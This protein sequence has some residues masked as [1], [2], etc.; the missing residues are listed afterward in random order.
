[1]RARS[2]PTLLVSAFALLGA[3][4][5]ND[6]STPAANTDAGSSDVTLT[7]KLQV[8]AGAETHRCQL[9]QLPNRE[10]WVSGLEHHYTKGSHHFL[11]YATTL[12][13]IPAG[14]EGQT[15]CAQ[16]DEGPFKYSAGLIY[17]SQTADGKIPFPEGVGM[18]L[19]AG[20]VFMIQ[21]HYIN[22]GP[23]PIDATVALTFQTTTAD[24][25]KVRAAPFLF[26]DP[27]IYVPPKS[28]G[29]SMTQSC[30]MPADITILSAFS[31]YHQR[32]T[33]MTVWRDPNRETQTTNVMYSSNDWEN[34]EM[35]TGAVAFKK[36]EHVRFQCE[37]D[38]TTS[39]EE[40]IQGPRAKVNEMCA[41]IGIYYPE[42]P[43]S[44][45]GANNTD[46]WNCGHE[47]KFTETGTK[48]A[49]FDLAQCLQACPPGDAPRFHPG[50][51]DIGACWQKCAA[52]AC[53]NSLS[54]V[55]PLSGCQQ[56]QCAEECKAGN[57]V[58]CL[59]T[60]CADQFNA[61]AAHS[62]PTGG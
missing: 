37:Y 62:C 28:L 5:S 24:K 17:A 58:A 26:F 9:V 35:L 33:K 4:S 21:S 29:K 34:P 48:L 39:P 22:A 59:T 42:Q 3:C 52:D 8:P 31:H 6:S 47:R 57:C 41:F 45:A 36:G 7:M 51:V 50:G 44:P 11:M 60:K 25:V 56:S 40:V 49:C 20:A 10:V 43:S 27:F 14:E 23:T 19:D 38:N 12:K 2:L 54:K 30:G 46:F 1:M 61:C 32:G 18:H 55:F 53:P 13:S 15:E 16:G